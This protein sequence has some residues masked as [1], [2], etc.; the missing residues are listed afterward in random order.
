MRQFF[1]QKPETQDLVRLSLIIGLIS[2]TRLIPHPP[3]FTPV[4]AVAIFG[5]AHL[6]S[7]V[8]A[9]TIPIASMMISDSFLGFHALAPIIYITMGFITYLSRN[10]VFTKSWKSLGFHAFLSAIVFFL[11]TNLAV[12]FFTPLYPH[13]LGGLSLCFTLAIPFFHYSLLANLL[14]LPVMQTCKHLSSKPALEHS[15]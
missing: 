8:L 10:I 9:Y 7:P 14:Y 3:N 15:L 6:R 2:L 13:T 12:W 4:M 11:V 1:V 5:G